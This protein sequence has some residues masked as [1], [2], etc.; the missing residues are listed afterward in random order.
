MFSPPASTSWLHPVRRSNRV[1]L[2]TRSPPTPPLAGEVWQA[3]HW[4]SLKAGPRPSAGL[5][6]WLNSS[7]PARKRASSAAPRPGSGAPGSP[8]AAARPPHPAPPSTARSRS[9]TPSEIRL[10]DPP[11]ESRS[12]EIGRQPHLHDLPGLR[13]EHVRHV[14]PTAYHEEQLDHERPRGPGNGEI[15]R[16]SCRERV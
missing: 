7:A 6:T 2:S 4:F 14:V 13:A 9:A 16:A 15:G 1:A 10:P 5:N 11:E 3:L 8:V 12:I